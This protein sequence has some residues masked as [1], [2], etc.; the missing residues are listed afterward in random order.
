M[1]SQANITGSRH[2]AVGFGALQNCIAPPDF[3]GNTAVGS[4]ALNSDTTGNF[5]TAVG[6]APILNTTGGAN[7]AI[8]LD[9]LVFND[10]GDRTPPPAV[11]RSLTTPRAYKT[12]PLALTPLLSNTYRQPTTQLSVSAAL[13]TNAC[14]KLKHRHRLQRALE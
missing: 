9:A 5:N 2:T 7:T 12:R 6:D 10:T 1:R 8:G 4:E 14:R 3:A 13:V 11:T